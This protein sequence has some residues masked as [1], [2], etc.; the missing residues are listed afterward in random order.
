[1]LGILDTILSTTIV[2]TLGAST[3]I[4]FT[5]PHKPNSQPRNLVGG[6]LMGTLAGIFCN[7]LARLSIWTQ[8]SIIQ[9]STDIVFGAVAVGLA[10]FLM[11]VTDTEHPPAAGLALGYML[12]ECTLQVV[13]VVFIG[14]LSLAGIK[15]LLKSKL[16]D[17]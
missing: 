10:I 8:I 2:A 6:Y 13:I 17:L 11:V 3:F 4:A 9:L 5:M 16:I 7:F 14:I 15:S 1:V 12:N